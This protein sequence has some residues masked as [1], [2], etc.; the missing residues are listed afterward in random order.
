MCL[1]PKIGPYWTFQ[2]WATWVRKWGRQIWF[3][4]AVL[5]YCQIDQD[6]WQKNSDDGERCGG[7]PC[8]SLLSSVGYSQLG[9]GCMR[10]FQQSTVIFHI[11]RALIS[12][13]V[14]CSLTLLLRQRVWAQPSSSPHLLTAHSVWR[15]GSMHWWEE[16]ASHRGGV[17]WQPRLQRW[18][19][20]SR[21]RDP[22][23]TCATSLPTFNVVP[24]YHHVLYLASHGRLGYDLFCHEVFEASPKA[25]SWEWWKLRLQGWWLG[26]VGLAAS[27]FLFEPGMS[28]IQGGLPAISC[29]AGKP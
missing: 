1:A 17:D 16:Q 9:I 5:R 28:W 18:V 22:K 8:K 7:N 4:D 12:L 29:N 13:P 20:T 15:K 23:G 3:R 24:R 25:K 6:A 14:A 19:N 27:H 2:E 11:S 10:C 26:Y 21:R